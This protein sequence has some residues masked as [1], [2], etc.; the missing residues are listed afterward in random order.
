MNAMFVVTVPITV[1]VN[2]ATAEEATVFAINGAE[3]LLCDETN[4]WPDEWESFELASA[5]VKAGEVS[6]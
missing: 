3:A 5:A 1:R 2:A 4:T 6:K